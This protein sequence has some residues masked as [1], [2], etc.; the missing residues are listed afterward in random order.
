MRVTVPNFDVLPQWAKES[1][2]SVVARINNTFQKQHTGDGEHG[3]ITAESVISVDGIICGEL[4]GTHGN[5]IFYNGVNG[6]TIGIPG[7][8]NV[9]KFF[10]VADSVGTP[11]MIV[12]PLGTGVFA[13]GTRSTNPTIPSGYSTGAGGTVTQATSKA[14]GVTL[15]KVTGQI[16]MFNDALAGGAKVSFVVTNTAVAAVDAIT[17]SVASGGTANAY[18]AA[19]TAVAAS[20]FTITVENITGGSLSESPVINFLVWKGASS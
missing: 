15:S 18:R 16:T 2:E 17:V 14:T 10:I 3:D 1:F 13:A 8:G 11:V 4:V 6:I 12:N 20:S 19:V 9:S 5:Q 7:T